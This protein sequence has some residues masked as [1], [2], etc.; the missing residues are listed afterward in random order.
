[1]MTPIAIS[2]GATG[3]PSALTSRASRSRGVELATAVEPFMLRSAPGDPPTTRPCELPLDPSGRAG[4]ANHPC[5][6][7]DTASHGN[8]QNVLCRARTGAPIR[9]TSMRACMPSLSLQAPATPGRG[10]A[11]RRRLAGCNMVVLNPTGDIA[12]QQRNLILI[13]TG[14][15]LLI[16]VPVL[17]L[18]V[19]FAWRY[20][21][22]G[23]RHL[24]SPLRP[25]DPARAGDL[26]LPAADH[27]LPGRGHLVE[28]ASARPV[29]AAR[30]HRGRTADTAGDEDARGPGRGDGLEVDVHLPRAGDRRRS[31]SWRC[32]SIRRCASR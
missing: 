10:F 2:P 24:R 22:G 21:R 26:G 17:V 8:G 27:H 15:M 18:M 11:A 4:A 32:R 6:C 20:R 31:T 5:S 30:P 13:A 29:P 19:V 1:M 14:L 3:R 16:I 25:F 28:H 12:I 23:E 7:R 9:A